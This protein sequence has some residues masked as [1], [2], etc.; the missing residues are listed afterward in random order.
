MLPETICLH[1]GYTP[2]NGDPAALPIYQSTTFRY[3]STENIAKLFD[4]KD[5]GFFY[6]R[7]G[8]PTVD[9]VEQKIAALEG[10]VGA[11]CTS[12]GMAACVGIVLTLAKAGDHIVCSSA[13]YGGTFNLLAVSLKKIGIETTFIDQSASD[14]EISSAFRDNT[15][16][17]IGETLANPAMDVL[18][19]ERLAKIAHQHKVPFVVDN[20]FATPILCRPGDFGADIVFHATTKYMD[21]HAIQMGGVVVDIGSFD[22]AA[23]GKFPDFVEPDESYH[24]T[25]Y[26]RDFGK[27]AFIVKCR[28]QFM[29][30]YGSCQTAQGAFYINLGLET[31]PLRIVQHSKNGLEIARMLAE[32]PKIESISYPALE[33]D[34]NHALCLKYLKDGM[35]SGVMSVVLKG[36]RA[37]GAKFIDSVKLCS[38]EVHVADIRSC[39]LHPASATHRQLTDAQLEACGIKP[40]TVRISVGIENIAD[41]KED[42]LQALAQV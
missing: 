36:G 14:E 12:S 4:L 30:D 1:A 25:V 10:G 38:P 26:T 34:P 17:F 27:A 40:G 28:V 7:L 18:D 35:C 9:A 3:D 31:L 13:V 22:Y 24:G 20:T 6:S 15:K 21:G 42:I 2:K 32:H 11:M 19:I 8:N 23:S 29:R 16:L 37:A 5:N 33:H 39:V 41:I